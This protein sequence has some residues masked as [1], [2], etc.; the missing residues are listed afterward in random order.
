[1]GVPSSAI[2]GGF[3]FD[4]KEKRRRIREGEESEG[5]EGKRRW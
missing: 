5:E 4:V 1:M 3:E 2:A